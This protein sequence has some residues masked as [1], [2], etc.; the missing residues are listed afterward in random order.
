M[1]RPLNPVSDSPD[2]PGDVAA[3]QL[4]FGICNLYLAS[5]NIHAH[6]LDAGEPFK[7][8]A[9]ILGAT[10]TIIPLIA[11]RRT[12]RVSESQHCHLPA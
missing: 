3:R 11:A 8:L 9:D 6:V 2:G 10:G 4:A 7:R 1:S 12:T 5:D